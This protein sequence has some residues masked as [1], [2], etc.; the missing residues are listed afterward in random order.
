MLNRIICALS[1]VA[2]LY[3]QQPSAAPRGVELLIGKARALEARGRTDLAAQTWQQLLMIDPD[4]QDAIA[5]LARAARAQGKTA[6]AEE[7]LSRLRKANPA[8]PAIKQIESISTG[9]KRN[10]D[11]EDASRFAAAGQND[12]AVTSYR[13]AFGSKVPEEWTVPYNETLASTPGGWEQATASLEQALR[14]NPA[15]QGYK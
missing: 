8:N 5:G 6:E 1:A 9:S 15:S 2:I 13:K 14:K 11:I 12:K 3:A 10:P 4:Q 7:Y